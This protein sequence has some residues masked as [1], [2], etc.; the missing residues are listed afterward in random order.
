MMHMI[1]AGILIEVG[2]KLTAQGWQEHLEI[3]DAC[4]QK[5]GHTLFMVNRLNSKFL[6][7]ARSIDNMTREN[8]KFCRVAPNEQLMSWEKSM[9]TED[10]ISLFSLCS[11]HMT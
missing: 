9:F 11:W 2:V 3:I 7:N 4:I 5:V 1:I 6:L 8:S 10:V